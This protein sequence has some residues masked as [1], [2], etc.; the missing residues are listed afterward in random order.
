[1]FK[2]TTDTLVKSFL[3]VV[4]SEKLTS[5][6]PQ[7]TKDL[8]EEAKK[9]TDKFQAVVWTRVP[10]SPSL[11]K[12]I[13]GVLGKKVGKKLTVINSQ[14]KDL[15]G[16]FKIEYGDWVYDATLRKNFENIHKLLA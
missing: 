1:M 16:G 4:A 6:L 12:K 13:A 9:Q 14:D 2:S 8:E 5:S 10:V 15:V 3:E 7:I 11:L